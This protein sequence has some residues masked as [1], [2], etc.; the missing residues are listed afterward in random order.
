MRLVPR[1]ARIRTATV[2]NPIDWEIKTSD[3]AGEEGGRVCPTL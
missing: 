2:G 3:N 1:P